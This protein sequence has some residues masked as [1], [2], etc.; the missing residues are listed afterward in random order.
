M[1]QVSIP[2]DVLEEVDKI[3]S[4]V[5]LKRHEVVRVAV[6]EFVDKHRIINLDPWQTAHVRHSFLEKAVN[7]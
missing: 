6:L 3:A 4:A 7:K 2:D 5:D 1:S